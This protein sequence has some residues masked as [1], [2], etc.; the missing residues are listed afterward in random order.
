M[1]RAHPNSQCPAHAY[2]LDTATGA[3]LW[4]VKVEQRVTGAP[5]PHDGVVYVHVLG[6]D[7]VNTGE[8]P[9]WFRQPGS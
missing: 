1:G 2:A 7:D 4:T 5:T 8:E 6:S 3:L 9:A